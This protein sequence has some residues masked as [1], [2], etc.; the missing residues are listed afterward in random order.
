MLPRVTM[1]KITLGEEREKTGLNNF[2]LAST[3]SQ[4]GEVS[5]TAS[6]YKATLLMVYLDP[7]SLQETESSSQMFWRYTQE[8]RRCCGCLALLSIRLLVSLVLATGELLAI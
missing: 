3:L 1:P 7:V 5:S 6:W 8:A 2:P 4:P